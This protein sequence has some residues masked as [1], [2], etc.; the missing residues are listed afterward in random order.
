MNGRSYP[1]YPIPGVGGIVVAPQG[2]LMVIRDKEPAKGLLSIPGG[3]VEIGETQEHA[4]VRE[5]KEETGVDCEVIRLVSTADLIMS[6]TKG[7][8]EYHF[9]LNHYL[10]KALTFKLQAETPIAQP[11]WVIPS[12]LGE[13]EIPPRI[14]ELL[15][16]NLDDIESLMNE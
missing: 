9:I 16:E 8:I 4:I 6:D 14:I 12:E 5:V 2:V 15:M 11:M 13:L 1:N 10:C 3:A 7:S